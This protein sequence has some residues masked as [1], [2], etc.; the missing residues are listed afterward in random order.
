M[1]GGLAP[2]FEELGFKT[3]GWEVAAGNPPVFLLRGGA[4]HS[5][6]GAQTHPTLCSGLILTHNWDGSWRRDRRR[7][8]GA[9]SP[10]SGCCSSRFC[11]RPHWRGP[12]GCPMGI[13]I[14]K[15]GQQGSACGLGMAQVQPCPGQSRSRVRSCSLELQAAGCTAH[16]R[17]WAQT[18]GAKVDM[19]TYFPG[20]GSRW[21]LWRMA[22]AHSL[23][24][25]SKGKAAIGPGWVGEGLVGMGQNGTHTGQVLKAPAQD[26][27]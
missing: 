9:S 25:P 12:S 11:S 26:L 1:W 14:R 3:R 17:A 8:H 13:Y 6:P 27:H 7:G 21:G 20:S 22:P 5:L 19:D 18:C 15:G 24:L 16:L 10:G 2:Q 23:P 4:T